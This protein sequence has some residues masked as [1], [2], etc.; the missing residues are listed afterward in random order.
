MPGGAPGPALD[1]NPFGARG[2][3]FNETVMWFSMTRLIAAVN[4]SGRCDDPTS[5]DT[6]RM[7]SA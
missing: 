1:G 3:E 5:S 4:P 6:P 7:R 2:H